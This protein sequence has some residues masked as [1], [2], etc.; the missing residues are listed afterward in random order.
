MSVE[1]TLKDRRDPHCGYLYVGTEKIA[2]YHFKLLD[3]FRLVARFWRKRTS[4]LGDVEMYMQEL[5]L[6]PFE[7]KVVCKA[8]SIM[9]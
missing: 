4:V 9:R 6:N 8:M 7:S 1:S 5:T 3:G 2:E